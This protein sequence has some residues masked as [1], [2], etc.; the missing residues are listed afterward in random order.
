MTTRPTIQARAQYGLRVVERAVGVLGARVRRPPVAPAPRVAFNAMFSQSAVAALHAERHTL[1]QFDLYL[2]DVMTAPRLKGQIVFEYGTLLRAV[3]SWHG[4]RVL[5]IG[6]GRSTFPKWMSSRGA[7]VT[8]FDLATPA[9]HLGGGFLG[10]VDR[11]VAKRSG[12]VHAVAGSMLTLPFADAS[13]DLVTCQTVLIHTPDPGAA[14]D[15]MIRVARPGGLIL[16]AEPNNVAGALMFD[17]INFHD[18]V[19]EIIARVRLQLVCERGKAAL[20]EGNNSIGELVPGLFAARGLLDI[21]VHLN[22]KT[23]AVLPPYGSAEQRS[24]LDERADLKDRDF[25]IWSRVD[26]HRYFLAGGG[27]EGEFE[28]LWSIAVGDSGQVNKAIAAGTYAGAGGAVNYLVAGRKPG[29]S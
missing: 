2:Y 8:T 3:P 13:F 20:G 26:T 7:V 28:A 11:V 12:V 5:D 21:R 4:L 6:T 22:D 1:Q 16:A 18:P 29:V 25:W 23:N 27:H 19:D 17:S 10:R 24:M 15:E 9:E 14:I